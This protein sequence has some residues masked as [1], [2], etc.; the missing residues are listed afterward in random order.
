MK[1]MSE[2]LRRTLGGADDESLQHGKSALDRDTLNRYARSRGRQT[3]PAFRLDTPT[4][5]ED[6]IAGS[7]METIHG[8]AWVIEHVLNLSKH[9]GSVALG[10]FYEGDLNDLYTLTGDPRLIGRHPKEGL[11]VDIEATGLAGGAGTQAFLIG[12]GFLEGE[13]FVLRQFLLRTPADEQAALQ[14]F[15]DYLEKYPLLISFNGKSYDLT[16]LQTRLIIHRFYSSLQCD[17]KLRPHLDLL[18]LARNLHRGRFENT[19]LSTLEERLLGFFREDDIPGH[20][21]PSCWLHFLRTADA[22]PLQKVVQH[23]FDDVVSMVVLAGRLMMDSNRQANGSRDP[24]TTL[25]LGHLLLRRGHPKEAI[26][27]L[28]PLTD[29]RGMGSDP[30]VCEALRVLSVA[31]RKTQRRELQKRSLISLIERCPDDLDALT[32]LSI[33]EERWTRDFATAYRYA[34]RAHELGVTDQ[35]TKRVARLRSRLAP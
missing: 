35:S 30:I 29:N 20:L 31:A 1:S 18:H 16:V 5:F 13:C 2:R 4:S 21:V 11:F 9:H 34:Q 33:L 3:E 22:G 7:P 32:A 17:L 23:N 27:V 14:L 25:N 19:K 12:L 6:A 24:H 28:H 10:A 8:E 26:E 15:V